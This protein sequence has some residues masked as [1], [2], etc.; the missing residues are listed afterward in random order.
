ML[1]ARVAGSQVHLR[2]HGAACEERQQKAA[3]PGT[4]PRARGSLFKAHPDSNKQEEH[5]RVRKGGLIASAH[6]ENLKRNTPA[7]TGQPMGWEVLDWS[8]G[9]LR[10]YGPATQHDLVT[11][12]E[13]GAPRAHGPAT[14]T[15]VRPRSTMGA[16]RRTR[17]SLLLAVSLFLFLRS[18]PAHGPASLD[19]HEDRLGCGAPPSIRAR[20]RPWPRGEPASP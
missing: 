6:L 15:N 4:P 10:A 8:E 12:I 18:T 14:S 11:I 13:G 19:F 1:S 2:G 17:A 16:P 9:A 5:N 3:S 20:C 7:H